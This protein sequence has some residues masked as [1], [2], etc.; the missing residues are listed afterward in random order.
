MM[1]ISGINYFYSRKLKEINE[2]MVYDQ[3]LNF[4]SSIENFRA[5]C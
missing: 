2:M 4:K 1:E 3:P 5:S